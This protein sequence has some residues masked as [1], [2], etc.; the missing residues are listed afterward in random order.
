VYSFLVAKRP[1]WKQAPVINVLAQIQFDDDLN[2]ETHM[3]RIQT[4]FKKHGFSGTEEFVE[5][6]Q[7]INPAMSAAVSTNR[8]VLR[9]FYSPDLLN[10]FTIARNELRFSTSQYT[11]FP[12]FKAHVNTGLEILN[13]LVG[14]CL[15]RRLGLRCIDL[16]EATPELPLD[17]QVDP[18]LLGFKLDHGD[19]MEMVMTQGLRGDKPQR[20]IFRALR[21]LSAAAHLNQFAGR[22]PY[23]PRLNR[24]GN[25]IPAP[26][27]LFVLDVDVFQIWDATLPQ[28]RPLLTEATT[29][30]ETFHEQASAVFKRSLTK[31]ALLHYKGP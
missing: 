8:R 14:P 13:K 29:I 16:L 31:A 18:S 4:A 22:R 30:L 12:A 2:I 10:V 27:S 5:E 1:G 19:G 15:V 24:S 17:K 20:M 6:T 7:L 11:T 28:P 21:E 23:F 3:D 25:Q 9:E 26:E